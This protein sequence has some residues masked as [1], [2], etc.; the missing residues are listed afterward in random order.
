MPSK[1]FEDSQKQLEELQKPDR[2]FQVEKSDIDRQIEELTKKRSQLENEEDEALIKKSKA[3]DTLITELKEKDKIPDHETIED[4]Y[5]LSKNGDAVNECIK[6][7]QRAFEDAGLENLDISDRKKVKYIKSVD[8]IND[9]EASDKPQ[10]FVKPIEREM[11]NF[12]GS[13]Y[14]PPRYEQTD[15]VLVIVKLNNGTDP[16][17]NTVIEAVVKTT[18]KDGKVSLEMDEKAQGLYRL[19]SQDQYTEAFQGTGGYEGKVRRGDMT[20]DDYLESYR[21]EHKESLQN[22]HQ[23]RDKNLDKNPEYTASKQEREDFIE[24]ISERYTAQLEAAQKLKDEIIKK[25][26][27]RIAEYDR[28]QNEIFGSDSFMALLGTIG[29]LAKEDSERRTR[30]EEPINERKIA[31]LKANIQKLYPSLGEGLLERMLS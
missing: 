13:R 25:A 21:K 29:L 23:R 10:I 24:G 27:E 9:A 7:T 26:D 14:R 12:W 8:E 17:E 18:T 5:R 28:I 11:R 4:M 30:D 31:Q 16:K 15:E 6:L 3:V 2:D 1:S 20:Y 22:Y 19:E